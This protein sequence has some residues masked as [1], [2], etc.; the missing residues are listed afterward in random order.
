MGGSNLQPLKNGQELTIGFVRDQVD[1]DEFYLQI[2]SKNVNPKT[3]QKDTA[4]IPVDDIDEIEHVEGTLQFYLHYC[5]STQTAQNGTG[6]IGNLKM[7]MK[8][9]KQNGDDEKE[10]RSDLF[11]TKFVK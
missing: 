6:F 9:A 5:A 7:K 8:G 3:G 4:K 11:E 10:E 1:E 2:V